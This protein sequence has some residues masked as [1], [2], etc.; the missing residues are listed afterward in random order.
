MDTA[1][2]FR[3]TRWVPCT[4]EDTENPMSH[5]KKVSPPPSV[6][7]EGSYCPIRAIKEALDQRKLYTRKEI[8]AAAQDKKVEITDMPGSD[9]S[10]GTAGIVVECGMGVDDILTQEVDEVRS[11]FQKP[12]FLNDNSGGILFMRV[13][14]Q[15]Q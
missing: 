1:E 13:Q 6:I 4:I 11:Q 3:M 10:A 15:G 14:T 8:A 5:A 2:T 9:A 7:C 12:R